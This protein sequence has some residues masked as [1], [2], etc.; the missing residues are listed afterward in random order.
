MV[1]KTKY[2]YGIILNTNTSDT[3]ILRAEGINVI[4]YKDISA[5]VKDSDEDDCLNLTKEEMAKMLVHHQQTIEKVMANGFSIVPM[6]LGT[7]ADSNHEI[8]NILSTG[9]PFIKNILNEVDGKIEINIIALWSDFGITLKE[10]SEEKEIHEFKQKLMSDPANITIDDQKKIGIMIG[11]ALAK[12]KKDYADII[13]KDLSTVSIQNVPHEVMNDQMLINTAFLIDQNEQGKFDNMVDELNSKCEDKLN[14]RYVG[15]LPCYSLYT[16]EVEHIDFDD[17]QWAKNKL[18]LNDTANLKEI[19]KAYKSK[20]LK[21]HPDKN[22][23]KMGM[24]EKF[25]DLNIA[26][27]TLTA[28]CMIA[29]NSEGYCSF[30]ED[31]VNNNTTIIKLKD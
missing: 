7:F 31:D 21:V 11:T 28:Y 29:V 25:H 18:A 4:S 9:Y 3:S 20:A 22:M 19:K 23:D 6:K 10:I 27:K 2:I 26:Y 17:I 14:F 15:P 24:D 30:M 5:V 13:H 16:L 8:E 12:K 1:E